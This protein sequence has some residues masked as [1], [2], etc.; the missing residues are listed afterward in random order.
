MYQRS[1]AHAR[2]W[3]QLPNYSLWA[4]IASFIQVSLKDLISGVRH[5]KGPRVASVRDGILPTMEHRPTPRATHRS[6]GS[7]SMIAYPP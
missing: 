7:R 1:V 4:G 5:V 3:R 6:Y 2:G